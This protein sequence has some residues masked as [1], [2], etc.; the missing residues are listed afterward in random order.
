MSEVDFYRDHIDGLRSQLLLR[1]RKIEQLEAAVTRGV[2]LRA[3]MHLIAGKIKQVRN[4]I[5]DYDPPTSVL[6]RWL[7]QGVIEHMTKALGESCE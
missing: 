2:K 7:D 1:D 6:I 3:Q 5:E 4:Y